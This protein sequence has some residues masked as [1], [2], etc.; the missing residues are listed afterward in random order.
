MKAVIHDEVGS[1]LDALEREI[2]VIDDLNRTLEGV[3]KFPDFTSRRFDD[4]YSTTLP[5][6]T[7]HIETIATG[8]AMQTLDLG[9]HRRKWGLT[10]RG[11]QGSAE[12]KECDIRVTLAKDHLQ[13]PNAA[14]TYFTACNRLSTKANAGIILRFTGTYSK[15]TN[16]SKIQKIW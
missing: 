3:E 15:G 14:E 2:N 9:M 7:S 8:L 13:I 1:R 4:L 11:L 16:G 6:I 5:A 12:E 10:I